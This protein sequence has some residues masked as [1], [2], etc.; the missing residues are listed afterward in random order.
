MSQSMHII[1]T[2]AFQ[3]R[4]GACGATGELEI[5]AE[6]AEEGSQTHAC[7]KAGGSGDG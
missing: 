7:P 3:W 5:T 1:Q 6:F 2:P 4:C